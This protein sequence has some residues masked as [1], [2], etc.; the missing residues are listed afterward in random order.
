[1][2]LKTL[3]TYIKINL[4]NGFIHSSKSPT[5]TPILFDKKLNKS[6]LLCVN[7]Q[8]LNN[9]TIKNQYL[10]L[11]V[12]ESLNCLGYAK[13]FIQLDLTGGYHRMRINESDKLKIAF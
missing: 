8:G 6:L 13:Q 12:S 7:Y 1:M 3:K 5:G 2:K 4:A 11:F 10:F 9:I